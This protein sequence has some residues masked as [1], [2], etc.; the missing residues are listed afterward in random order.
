MSTPIVRLMQRLSYP[1]RFALIGLV[2]A[3]ALLYLVYGLYHSNQD[4]IDS[5]TKERVGVVYM[6]PLAGLLAAVQ[7]QQDLAVHAALGD[8]QAKNALAAGASQLQARWQALK[9]VNEQLGADLASGDAWKGAAA[10]W[11]KLQALGSATPAQLIAGYGALNDQLN[12]LIGVISDN[13]NL[14]LDPD[15]DTY[16]LMDAATTKLTSVLIHLGEANAIAALAEANQALTPAQRDRLVELRP[17]IAE[18][19]DGLG[20]DVGKAIAYNA[21]LKTGL[22]A[23]ADKL[24]AILKSQSAALFDAVA[25]KSGAG[26]LKVAG[27]TAENA[28]AI[29][30]YIALE[31]KQL[32]Q[33]LQA[34]IDRTAWQRNTYIGI[35]IAAMLLA[36]FLF[37]QL[38]LSITLQLGGEPFYVQQVVEQ[39]AAG[40]LDTQ[41]Q[42]R[43]QDSQSL[44]ASIRQM[45]DQL[46]ETVAQLLD[47]SN[48]VNNAAAQMAQSARSITTSSTLQN[49]AAFSMAAAIEQLSASLTVSAEQSEHANQ[50]SRT[51]VVQSTAGDKVI[52]ATTTSMDGIVRD[53]SSVS[54]TISDLSRQSESIVSIVDVIRDVADQTNLLALNAA[55]EAARAGEMGRGFAVVA[56][57]VRKLAERTAL[58]T[59]EISNIVARIQST[60]QKGSESMQVG[61]QAI[62]DGLQRSRDAGSSMAGIRHCVDDVLGSI[63][64]IMV[65]LQ[66]QSSASQVLAQNVEQVSRMSEQ[67][68]SEVKASAQT[69]GELQA[70][71]QRLMGLA[72]RFTV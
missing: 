22:S 62:M 46:R 16:Y 53:V 30:D 24:A 47:T 52:S 12:N 45:R 59:T 32:D 33:L 17:L 58:S 63:N 71:S 14:T 61:M 70:I 10:S 41:I 18:A 38:Y 1:Q 31:L 64:Q 37:Q 27:H 35:G 55:I 19:G 6:Q 7:Q 20:S 15:I 40:R 49:E 72:S 42:L 25:G 4:N 44:L 29:A 48:E 2:F 11:D 66:E 67:N 56:D 43:R 34:R 57:E 21:S 50:L 69:A 8:G 13:S 23:Q 36:I 5:T 28:P 51:A 3:A 68:A 39:L 26:G 54:E 60:A 9:T 65:S